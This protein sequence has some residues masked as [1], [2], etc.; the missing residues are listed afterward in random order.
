MSH[1]QYFNYEGAFAERSKREFNYSQVVRI[2]NRI[3]VS[4]Q[5][6]QR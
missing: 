1:L 4:G 3:E 2:D 6:K 5:G